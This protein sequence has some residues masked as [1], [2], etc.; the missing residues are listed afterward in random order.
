MYLISR[1]SK[2][3][4][5]GFSLIELMIALAIIGI[6][7][8]IAYPSYQD[9]VIKNRRAD[10]KIALTQAAARL[11]RFFTENNNYGTTVNNIGGTGGSLKSPESYYSLSMTN[12]PCGDTSCFTLTA[13]RQG[14]QTKDTKC[15]DL[16]LSSTGAKGKTGSL[17]VEDCW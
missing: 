11:E 2:S 15:G 13:A 5:S 17:N 3:S 8:A 4:S 12:Q 10:G 1:F 9:S 16:S 6:L 7:A 14:A